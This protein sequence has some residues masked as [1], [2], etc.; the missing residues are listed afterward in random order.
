[1]PTVLFFTK[2]NSNGRQRWPEHAQLMPFNEHAEK[3]FVHFLPNETA[4]RQTYLDISP[5][6]FAGYL[7]YE[8]YL[9]QVASEIVK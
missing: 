1:M 8:L 2:N 6:R 5:I 7:L 9:H 4:F 3:R